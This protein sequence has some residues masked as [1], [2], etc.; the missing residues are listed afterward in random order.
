MLWLG[1]PRDE[2][3]GGGGSDDELELIVV[4]EWLC[5]VMSLVTWIYMDLEDEMR[6]GRGD[7]DGRWNE[8]TREGRDSR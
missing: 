1:V 2:S 4:Q 5:A 6:E 3:F 7:G 8:D